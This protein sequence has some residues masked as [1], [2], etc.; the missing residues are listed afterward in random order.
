MGDATNDR[1]AELAAL[2]QSVWLDYISRSLIAGGGLQRLI[3]QDG[4]AGMTSN[5]SIFEKAIGGG[6]E[7]SD[8]IL[9]LARQG[10]DGPQIF[11]RLADRRRAGGLRRV[12]AGVRRQRRRGRLRVARGVAGTGSRHRDARS[13]RPGACSPPWTG[14]T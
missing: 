2:G 5:P 4:I 7:Y 11:D 12:H 8:E 10:H 3:D 6:D 14:R 13:P 9:A 1:L